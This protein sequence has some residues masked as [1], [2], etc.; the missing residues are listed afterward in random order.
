MKLF[1]LSDLHLGKRFFE[2]SLI[3]DQRVVLAQILKA[4]ETE[5]P[6]AVMIAGDVYDRSVPC[7][8]AVAL[9]D[10][11]L[12]ALSIMNTAVLIISGNHDSA[13]RLSFGR[14]IMVRGKVY[15]SPDINEKNY[16]KLLKPVVLND[17]FGEVNFWLLPYLTPSSVRT[18]RGGE[19]SDWTSAVSA[20][21][22]DMS[23][24]V[25]KRN[26]II[27]HQFVTGAETCESETFS[28]G[29]TDNVNADVFADFDYAA[30]GHLHGKQCVSKETVRYCGSPLKYSFS[31]VN[32][33]KSVT[34]VTLGKKGDA[35]MS[36]IHLDKPLHEWRTLRGKFAEITENGR[37]D[38]YIEAVLTDEQEL[39]NA[40]SRLREFFPNIMKMSFENSQTAESGNT[41]FTA[42]VKELRPE[43]VFSE[44]YS[45]QRGSK[46]TEEQMEIVR[47]IFESVSGG[48]K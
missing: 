46:L 16:E 23:I 48:Q 36:E 37:S 34:V 45:L 44:F 14:E 27:A 20:V 17:E 24:D 42:N 26:V 31:E 15:I 5:K 41:E 11:F 39:P 3:D 18:A 6:D 21:V 2:R 33:H 40:M 38:D 10:D 22:S 9:F 35:S 19:I 7:E 12:Y 29:G 1:H 13:E 32:H 4:A 25:S 8:E 30:L 28:V 47:E 43:D